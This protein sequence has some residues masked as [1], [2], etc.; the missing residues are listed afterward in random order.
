ML[1]Q[2]LQITQQMLG[3][4]K[5]QAFNPG[6]LKNYINIMRGKLA[7]Q[8]ACIR[9]YGTINTVIGQQ[10]Y[11]FS[12][13]IFAVGGVQGALNLRRL[14]YLVGSGAKWVTPRSWE[15]FELYELN[16]PVPTSGSPITWA[17]H[18]QGSASIGDITGEGA[19]TINSGSFWVSPIPD[20]VYTLQFDCECYP[21]AL[22]SDSDVEAIPYQ[23]TDAIPYGA[24][25]MAL[26]ATG[27]PER[28]ADADKFFSYFQQ[29]AQMARDAA[30]P[31][32]LK[33][34]YARQPNVT[35]PNQ[36]GM[37]LPRG[38]Q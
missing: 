5:G 19:G 13:L 32:I 29:Y 37:N 15:W 26:L 7:G 6:F 4:I 21:I 11:S 17:Q 3:D 20:F 9:A 12:S 30:N 2:Y 8:S 27:I 28:K 1:S 23:W 16:N 36:L 10:S 25:W 24:A 34:Q 38:G 35:L 14:M 22:N 33:Y 18:H 31:D